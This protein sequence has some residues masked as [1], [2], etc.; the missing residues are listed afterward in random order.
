MKASIRLGI[1]HLV[2][3][4]QPR[5]QDV[6][7]VAPADMP[8]LSPAI[9]RELWRIAAEQPGRILIPMLA[10][11]PGHPVLLP[12]SM[13]EQV[14]TLDVGEG[15]NSLIERNDPLH[16]PCD[17]VVDPEARAFVDIDTPA[18]LDRFKKH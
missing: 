18:D 10:G 14:A 6:W 17:R 3:I 9:I 15:L 11:R 12:W 5:D 1:D 2:E 13:A 8:G 7:L 4:D 16:A